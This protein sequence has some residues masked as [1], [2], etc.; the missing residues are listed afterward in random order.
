MY[1]NLKFAIKKLTTQILP[2]E[3]ESQ[4][5]LAECRASFL[6]ISLCTT[7]RKQTT[8]DHL[9]Q[10]LFVEGQIYHFLG[11]LTGRRLHNVQRRP[12]LN[13]SPVEQQK[14]AKI[15]NNNYETV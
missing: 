4:V 2:W 14:D 9:F 1:L 11:T 8:F 3:G 6:L 13:N 15:H 5:E 10:S 7:E 12:E